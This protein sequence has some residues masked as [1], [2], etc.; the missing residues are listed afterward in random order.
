MVDDLPSGCIDDFKG[1]QSMFLK[2]FSQ[3]KKSSE[4]I[5]K[6]HNIKRKD[7]ETVEQFMIRF[8][9]ESLQISGVVDQIRVSGFCHGVRHN[10]LVEKLHEDLPQSMEVLMD[11]AKSFVKGKKCLYEYGWG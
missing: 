5:I 7:S 11:R 8:N 9:K 1:F 6:I 2:Q 4:A 3:Q 10:Q